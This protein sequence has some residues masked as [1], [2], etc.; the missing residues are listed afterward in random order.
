MCKLTDSDFLLSLEESESSN[1]DELPIINPWNF[2]MTDNRKVSVGYFIPST[3]ISKY[4]SFWEVTN[5]ATADSNGIDNV[6]SYKEITNAQYL[7]INVLDKVREKFGV[8]DINSWFRCPELERK[9]ASAGYNRWLDKNGLTDTFANWQKYLANKQH[10]QGLAADIEVRGSVSNTEL[11]NW[12]KNNCEFDQL[13]LENVSN[14][15]DPRSGWVHVSIRPDGNNR[16]QAFK[17]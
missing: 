6:P 8:T 15:H 14:P 16:K 9:I 5:S 1:L 2:T 12:I 7:A 11:F 13:I 3:K 17:L 10:P 4:F